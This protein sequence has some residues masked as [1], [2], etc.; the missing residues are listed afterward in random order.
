MGK[1]ISAFGFL[2]LMI[3]AMAFFAACGGEITSGDHFG[4][5]DV[6]FEAQIEGE[7]DGLFFCADVK[8]LFCGDD[9]KKHIILSFS[10][11]HSLQGIVVDIANKKVS[12][13]MDNTDIKDWQA[14]E[15]PM[16]IDALCNRQSVQSIKKIS[17]TEYTL[18]AYDKN[19]NFEYIFDAEKNIPLKISGNNDS[20]SFSVNITDFKKLN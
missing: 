14:D 5:T 19:C 9:G 4:Y 2:L 16:Y 8:S 13:K 17:D 7:A 20:H 6:P 15:I 10:S 12:A 1:D 11:P 3:I 18:S